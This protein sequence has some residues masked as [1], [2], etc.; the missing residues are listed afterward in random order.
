[1]RHDD[2]GRRASESSTGDLRGN[3]LWGGRRMPLVTLTALI[4]VALALGAGRTAAAEGSKVDAYLSPG[5]EAEAEASP[6]ALFDV[7]VQADEGKKTDDV[8]DA[9][10][11][12]QKDWPAKG[13]KLKR[14]FISIAGTLATLTGKQ[15][16]KLAERSEIGSITRD[17]EVELL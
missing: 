14:K 12:A 1:M 16:M 7:I 4:V 17:V 13:S 15:L 3:A 8:A 9:V 2:V 5:L 11:K 10:T 6:D